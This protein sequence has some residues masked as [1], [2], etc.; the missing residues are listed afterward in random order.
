MNKSFYSLLNSK[1][2]ITQKIYDA[3]PEKLTTQF[4]HT[5][6]ALHL[7]ITHTIF[8]HTVASGAFEF[9]LS[10]TRSVCKIHIENYRSSFKILISSWNN[11]MQVKK[12]E[13]SLDQCFNYK[14]TNFSLKLSNKG[15]RMSLAFRAW[16]LLSCHC[17]SV[18]IGVSYWTALAAG[19][20]SYILC[21]LVVLTLGYDKSNILFHKLI[22]LSPP[23]I[24]KIKY[25]YQGNSVNILPHPTRW[26]KS[27]QPSV[28]SCG[29]N[30]QDMLCG[31]S[32]PL[33]Q[34][35]LSSVATLV[36]STMK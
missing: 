18:F 24:K 29:I 21:G 35:V 33:K 30:L 32:S 2:I 5:I 1:I 13:G 9:F 26:L 4:V 20:G 31:I 7:S 23:T 16:C 34:W 12:S 28:W 11:S 36:V 3:T 8:W 25:K 17:T 15:K 27:A 10:T 6:C 19:N 22:I 14:H